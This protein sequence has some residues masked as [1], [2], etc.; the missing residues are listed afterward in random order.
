VLRSHLALQNRQGSSSAR[1]LV[2]QLVLQVVLQP[3]LGS[4]NHPFDPRSLHA[5]P[6]LIGQ[7]HLLGRCLI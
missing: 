6:L 1:P 2:L 3:V 4:L 7:R 5:S